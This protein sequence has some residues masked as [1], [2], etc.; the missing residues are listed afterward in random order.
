MKSCTRQTVFIV[1][2]SLIL[3]FL[4]GCSLLTS[5]SSEYSCV[6]RGWPHDSSDLAP[7]P[8]LVFGQLENGLRYVILPNHEPAHRVGMYLDVQSG[9]LQETDEQQG[10]AH[11]LEHMLF[12]GTT[13]YPPGTL[14]EYFQSIGMGFGADTNA[15]TSYDET[16]Y[17][18]LLPAGDGQTLETGLV[19]MADYARG[20]MLLDQ[21]VDKERGIILAEKRARDSA[22][23]RL[24]QERMR[25][26]FAGTKIAERNPIGIDSTLQKANSALLRS[27]YDTW[28][29]PE[30]MI[31]VV[32][33][34][35]E[36]GLVQKLIKKNLSSLT[37]A[38]VPLQ[39]PD[40]GQVAEQGTDVFFLHEPDLG[41][42]SV[43][44]ESVWNEPAPADT[45]EYETRSL[46][47]YLAGIIMDNRLKHLVAQPESPITQANFYTGELVRLYRN[48]SL[49]AHTSAEKWQQTEQLL[50][51]TLQQALRFGFLEHE[52]DRAKLELFATLKKQQQQADSRNSRQLADELIYKLNAHEILFS[53][54]QEME[55]YTEIAQSLNL[56]QVNSAF[57][58]LWHPRRLIEVAGT[59]GKGVVKD[60]VT[61][62]IRQLYERS[63]H[64]EVLPWQG[65]QLAAF[66]YLPIPR[67]S[68]SVITKKE[69]AEIGVER[70]VFANGVVLN[71]KQ[72]DFA[73]NEVNIAVLF[74][75]GRLEEPVPGMGYL[76]QSLIEESGVGGLTKEQLEETLAPYSSRVRFV[77]GEES[78]VLSGKGLKAETE[79]LFQLVSTRLNDPAFRPAA[80]SRVM[81]QMAQM[82]NQL[83]RTSEGMMQ[84]KG[85]SFLAGN[86]PRYGFV[87]L[88]DMQK[89]TLKQV[90][91][92]IDAVF[93]NAALEISVVGDF[94]KQ[95][96][97]AW[98]GRYFSKPRQKRTSPVTGVQIRFPSGK[99]L[100]Q[101]V[102]SV[103]DRAMVT[104]AWPTEDFWDISRTRRMS[105]LATVL[106][107]RLRKQIRE[108]LGA[109]YSPV[110]YNRPSRV[111]PG[112]GV[113]RAQMIVAPPQAGM[114]AAKLRQIGAEM[115]LGK[116]SKDELERALEPVL[117][118]IRDMVRTNRYW[119]DSVLK[120]SNRHP[121]QLKWPRTILNDFSSITG[122]D[123]QALARQ[124]L[125]DEKAATVIIVPAKHLQN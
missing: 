22:R 88:N 103:T 61:A 100:Q 111:D 21:E 42:T 44:I 53:P 10:L 101:Q 39:C 105:I 125:L 102:D 93:A 48:S 35:A 56:D 12:N 94:V 98:A 29:R 50:S 19:V 14:V 2:Y 67:Q 75:H 65:N 46:A 76:A 123:I 108:E 58:Q 116:I 90:D 49:V 112:Y 33:G 78:F 47:E 73:P 62:E 57:Q 66:P 120:G 23:S 74:G 106:D 92:W 59:A 96:V 113:L 16:V 63:L 72:T 37:A 54:A 110:V 95:D 97:V 80:Y 121:V 40:F 43:A 86:N 52:L 1:V 24:F 71:L 26:A 64:A 79:L 34:D 41:Y 83:E 91:D 32:V 28:Y 118:S 99:T 13:H 124:Y 9:S 45:R 15:H 38:D 122:A 17:K 89:I 8:A 117:T 5:D 25:F 31:L 18:L 84:L 27:Y 7:D 68:S 55:L 69:Y 3:L 4:T 36:S 70:Y 107:D 77:V 82:Y 85:E 51:T 109:T 104:V 115:A 6:T 20:A 119:M 30:N 87:P 11:F 81:E 114:L 60:Q